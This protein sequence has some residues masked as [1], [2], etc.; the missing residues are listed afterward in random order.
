[1]WLY[2]IWS[3]VKRRKEII[4]PEYFTPLA[5]GVAERLLS[6]GPSQCRKVLNNTCR[7]ISNKQKESFHFKK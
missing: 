1:M 2:L 7:Q 4:C 3:L 6:I 5:I